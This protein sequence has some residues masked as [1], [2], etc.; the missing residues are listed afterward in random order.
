MG[1]AVVVFLIN[2]QVGDKLSHVSSELAQG[3]D[4]VANAAAQVREFSEAL[5]QGASE[6]A[7]SLEETSSSTSQ[8]SAMTAQNVESAGRAAE[9]VHE[10]SRY[11]ERGNSSLEEM[12]Q[13]MKE[14][15]SSSQQ[16]SKIIKLIDEIAFQ[17]NILSLNAAVEAAR[18]GEAGMGFAVVAGEVR[19]LA[20]RC[21]QAAKDTTD[22]IEVSH[23]RTDA[24]VQKLQMVEEAIAAITG[25]TS[26][27]KVLMDE[28]SVSS[29]EQKKGL[30]QIASAVEQMEQLTQ[31]NAASAQ[32]GAS[33]AQEMGGQS[34][35][36]RS[37]VRELE[38]FLGAQ[39]SDALTA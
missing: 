5:A 24:G 6:Q 28:V 16:I 38:A 23:S 37:V 30:D 34:E 35:N 18:A 22:L 12:I 15:S 8:V 11:V 10:T 3:S 33:Y 26:Q 32:E 39:R 31:R 13:S 21:A 25:V 27:L 14:I 2:R 19:N 4:Q 29:Q 36:L 1:I 7:S 9:L 17:T 20:Q